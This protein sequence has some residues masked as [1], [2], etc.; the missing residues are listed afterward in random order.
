MTSRITR[1]GASASTDVRSGH[2]SGLYRKALGVYPL[3]VL[4]A[5]LP[6]IAGCGGFT[7]LA[8][9]IF[10]DKIRAV[11][12]LEDRVTLVMVDDPELRL[13]DPI[14]AG[15]I[16]DRMR[17]DLQKAGAVREFVSVQRLNELIAEAGNEYERISIDR[18]GRD[19]GAEQVIHVSIDSLS[20][21]SDMGVMRPAATVTV[22]V[23]DVARG[24]RLFPAP[25]PA[26]APRG[27]VLTVQTAR[28][29]TD[30]GSRSD[31]S[32]AIRTLAQLIGRDV[33]RLFYDHLPRQPGDVREE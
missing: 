22:K 2:A 13:R 17:Q 27:V 9:A 6:A 1:Q 32:I 14:V 26:E 31:E 16:G 29:C 11:Y 28:R 19:L 30:Q 20:M 7:F 21:G 10:P 3:V 5:F 23:I 33:A 24:K 25:K 12:P 15:Q 18:V 8:Q 4:A